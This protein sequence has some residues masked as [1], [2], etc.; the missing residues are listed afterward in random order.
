MPRSLLLAFAPLY[1]LS[2]R[3]AAQAPAVPDAIYYEVPEM[4]A[5]TVTRDVT[6]RTALVS[7]REM[8]LTLDVYRP[9]NASS[10][11][12]RP[13]LIFVHG[14]LTTSQPK[15]A[16][17]WGV[18]RSWARVAAAS[19][20]VAVT[21]NHRLTTNDNVVEGGEDLRALVET[22]RTN[23][24]R[25]NVDPDRLC[26]A[27]YSAGGPLASVPLRDRP[28]YVKCVVLYYPFLD[29]EHMRHD[30]QFRPAH[31]T[32]HVDSVLDYSPARIITHD[33]TTVPPTFLAMAGRDAIPRL[34][35]SVVR[36]VQA[37]IDARIP[38]DFYLHPTGEHGFDRRNRDARTREIIEATLAFVK[39]H[40]RPP[41]R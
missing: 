33:P 22:V 4:E 19:G 29:L 2:A 12:R 3:A 41:A 14:G 34:N 26:L 23:A 27:F 6:Y 21:F 37:A 7:G 24:A 39:R 30:T 9:P 10:V 11:D 32:A 15:T 8:A 36:F 35:E 28:P 38:I 17:D 40:T 16:K 18:F 31:T 20:L 25:W 13:A 1:A 5:V